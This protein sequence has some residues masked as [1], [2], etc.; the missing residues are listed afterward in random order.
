[1]TTESKFAL[2]FIYILLQPV[3]FWLFFILFYFIYLFFFTNF[4][5]CKLVTSNF[6]V[7]AQ[8]DLLWP[9]TQSGKKTQVD[10]P[11]TTICSQDKLII[12][13]YDLIIT[14]FICMNH[15]FPLEKEYVCCTSFEPKPFVTTAPSEVSLH[16]VVSKKVVSNL[17][18]MYFIHE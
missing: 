13:H 12:Q 4:L 8:N 5:K 16:P 7:F 2:Y 9:F 18:F 17:C 1:M 11:T 10:L 3:F 14:T 6:I 15:I